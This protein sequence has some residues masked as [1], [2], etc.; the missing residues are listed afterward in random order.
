MVHGAWMLYGMSRWAG[1]ERTHGP[2]R[3]GGGDSRGETRTWAV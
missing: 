2:G 1:R 3:G